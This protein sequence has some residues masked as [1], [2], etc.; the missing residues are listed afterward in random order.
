MYDK[1]QLCQYRY[2]G[3]ILVGL[4]ILSLTMGALGDESERLTQLK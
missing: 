1:K 3:N 2:T 4:Q